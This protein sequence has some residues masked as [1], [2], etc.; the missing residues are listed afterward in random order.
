M[1]ESTVWS[2]LRLLRETPGSPLLLVS[3]GAGREADRYAL[4]TPAAIQ[5]SGRAHIERAR[6]EP[7]H[8][9]W[10]VLGLRGRALYE[11]IKAGLATNIDDAFAAAKLRPSN[12]YAILANLTT[13]GL[14]ERTNSTLT[15][16]RR[17]LDDVATAHGLGIIAADRILRH[18]AER[19]LWQVWLERRFAPPPPNGGMFELTTQTPAIAVSLIDERD[20]ER[21]WAVR[22]AEGP[23]ARDP[24]LDAIELLGDQL[25]AVIV[26]R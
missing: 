10:S 11:L 3:R 5:G 13:A 1:S 21:L 18:R 23:P 7:V 20:S 24:V 12:G 2:A 16:G 17:T 19:L 25:G 15:L 14:I 22:F 8:P 26:A 4:T 6:V 9:A